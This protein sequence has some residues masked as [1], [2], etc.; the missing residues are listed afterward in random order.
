MSA[1]AAKGSPEI[2][3][4]FC[5]RC[6]ISIPQI[7]IDTGRARP[8]PGGYVCVGCVYQHRDTDA[9][10]VAPRPRPVVVSRGDMGSRALVGLALLY[11]VGATTFL[12]VRELNREPPAQ[13]DLSQV[14][15]VDAVDRVARKVDELDDRNRVTLDQL[16]GNDDRQRDGL[17]DLSERVLTVGT[18]TSRLA[19]SVRSDV[20]DLQRLVLETMN[21]TGLLREDVN[22]VRGA[23]ERLARDMK[24]AGPVHTPEPKG[25]ETVRAPDT[26]EVPKKSA[27][28]LDRERQVKEYI[29]TL[30]DRKAGDKSNTERYNAAVQLGDLKDPAAIPALVDALQNDSY[31]LVQR[32]AAWSLGAFGQD[33]VPAIP[34]LIAQLAGKYEYVGYMCERA[35]GEI[36]KATMGSPVSFNF[37]PTMNLSARKKV[38]KKWE[39]WWE[40]NRDTLMPG[41]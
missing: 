16:K 18:E 15:T 22:T 4:H 33:A 26:P 31:D 7:D 14:A 21:R 32:A 28:D 20:T 23:L 12:L 29:A 5:Q 40:K 8:A 6:G 25:G 11:V 24:D 17:R 36:T 38:Q 35:L 37:D 3:L 10:A 13:V 27:D 19:Q 2:H 34:A 9:A 41:G 1:E 39:E 30:L